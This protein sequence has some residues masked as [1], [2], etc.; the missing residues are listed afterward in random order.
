M[1]D[2]AKFKN[3][4]TAERDRLIRQIN[5]L[6]DDESIN[7]RES[8]GNLSNYDNH[9]ADI[10]S[11]LYEREKDT[12]LKINNVEL[13][14]KVEKA[15]NAIEKGDF[16]L[17]EDCGK[18]INNQ[19]IEAIPYTLKCK[20]CSEIDEKTKSNRE[21]IVK[22]SI[23]SNSSDDRSDLSD[24]AWKEVEKYGTSSTELEH[25]NPDDFDE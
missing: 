7:F 4:L 22:H 3:L 12:A 15:L 17:C 1:H 24:E 21:E 16:G 11:E 20:S 6:S 19:R 18:E 14:N 2:V 5:N 23:G 8:V 9:P 25:Y 13:L 10:G